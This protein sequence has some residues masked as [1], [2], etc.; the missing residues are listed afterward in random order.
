MK[1][2]IK[3]VPVFKTIEEESD[4]WDNHEITEEN[5]IDVTEEFYRQLENDK[6]KKITIWLDTGLI[7]KLKQQSKKFGIPYQKFT[8]TILKASLA[9]I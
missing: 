2:K 4:Y 8:R 7:N 9:K 6:K 3:Q 5:S 1:T